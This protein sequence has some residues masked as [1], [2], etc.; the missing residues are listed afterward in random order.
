[1]EQIKNARY[2]SHL[3]VLTEFFGSPTELLST[4]KGNY[5]NYLIVTNFCD[6][7]D[8]K[9]IDGEI[10]YAQKKEKDFAKC[11]TI[12]YSKKEIINKNF[13]CFELTG[14]CRELTGIL[15]P[16]HQLLQLVIRTK[17]LWCSHLSFHF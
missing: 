15:P 6:F 7:Y 1:M 14:P 9:K 13:K 8:F 2:F 10:K 3:M 4:S 5:F 17:P 11:N 16:I 12:S